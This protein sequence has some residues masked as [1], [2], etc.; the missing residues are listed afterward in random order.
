MVVD[1][2]ARSAGIDISTSHEATVKT[3]FGAFLQPTFLQTSTYA[4]WLHGG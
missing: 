2:L 1:S 3:A 4:G